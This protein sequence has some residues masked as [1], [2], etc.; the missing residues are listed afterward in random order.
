[1]PLKKE[2]VKSSSKKPLKKGG[3]KSSSKKPL[4]KGGGKSSSKKPPL[5]NRLSALSVIDRQLN[6]TSSV[7]RLVNR[8]QNQSHPNALSVIHRELKPGSLNHRLQKPT[9]MPSKPSIPMIPRM[10]RNRT[11][12]VPEKRVGEKLES[13]LRRLKNAQKYAQY[14]IPSYQTSAKPKI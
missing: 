1:M 9:S 11:W 4:K 6:P 10:Q 13:L 14:I 7:N 3:V 8:L 12:H 2:G 5:E